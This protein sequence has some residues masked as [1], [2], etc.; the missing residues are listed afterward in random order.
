MLQMARATYHVTFNTSKKVVTVTEANLWT[1]VEN[2]LKIAFGADLC[3]QPFKLQLFS[4]EWDD[5]E[6]IN[7][8][9]TPPRKGKLQMIVTPPVVVIQACHKLLD[10]SQ[11]VSVEAN[12]PN[13]EK[14]NRDN[15]NLAQNNSGSNNHVESSNVSAW[16]VIN[17]MEV[18]SNVSVINHVEVEN[19][20]S[21]VNPVEVSQ[22]ENHSESKVTLVVSNNAKKSLPTHR[23]EHS[24]SQDESS[25]RDMPQ[26][27]IPYPFPVRGNM[28]P[29]KLWSSLMAMEQLTTK[30]QTDLLDGIYN[31]AAKYTV[32][33][34]SHEYDAMVSALL[35][36][37]PYL[38][39]GLALEDSV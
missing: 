13:Q 23:G 39:K 35:T 34:T 2:N 38:G 19:N 14:T 21:V 31:F 33:P 26:Q 37:V 36:T 5:F 30:Q 10:A 18:E 16:P 9:E 20:V 29:A 25:N 28:F 1:A 3:D 8:T 17:P 12:V 4:Q 32:Y 6:D 11:D 27:A 22:M 15:K 7:P 24:T